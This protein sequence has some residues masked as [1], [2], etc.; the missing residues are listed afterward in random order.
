MAGIV[1]CGPHN[2]E[3][4]RS[5][6]SYR[7]HNILTDVDTERVYVKRSISGMA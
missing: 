3:S 7:I 4:P 6:M 1:G 5:L 2:M